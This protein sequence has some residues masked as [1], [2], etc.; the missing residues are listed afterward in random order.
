MTNCG[1]RWTL[2]PAC[3]GR[4]Q[5]GGG[6]GGR[7]GAS[8]TAPVSSVYCQ[9]AAPP[10]SRGAALVSSRRP[11]SD[12]AGSPHPSSDWPGLLTLPSTEA[13]LHQPA[14]PSGA[15]MKPRV[16]SQ[17]GRHE[18]SP[19]AGAATK[20]RGSSQGRPSGAALPLR[21]RA[22]PAG[23]HEV[24]APTGRDGVYPASRHATPSSPSRRRR[25]RLIAG[26]ARGRRVGSGGASGAPFLPPAP[27]LF[28][29]GVTTP[30]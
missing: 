1:C 25:R 9:T 6:T 26:G 15:V 22:T 10:P 29:R 19:P 11:S 2:I 14:R 7:V 17:A 24:S 3:L 12:R 30:A 5:A 27:R 28:I 20:P 18:E 23:R 4:R 13:G 8:P 21:S 16:S